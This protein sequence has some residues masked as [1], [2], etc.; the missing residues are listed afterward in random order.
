MARLSCQLESFTVM[1]KKIKVSGKSLRLGHTL[2]VIST[3]DRNAN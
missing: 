1:Q 3:L 2:R